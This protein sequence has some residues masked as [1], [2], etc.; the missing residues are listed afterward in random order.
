MNRKLPLTSLFSIKKIKVLLSFGFKGYL[1]DQGWFNAFLSQS[2]VDAENKPIPW[3][4][5]PFIDFIKKRLNK[6][7][8]VFEYGAGN[9]TLFYSN[10]VKEVISVENDK[11]WIEK[12]SKNKPENVNFIYT[13]LFYDGEYSKMPKVLNKEFDIII[14]DGRDRV[15]CCKNSISSLKEGG[16]VILD[17]S[18]REQYSLAF[19]LFKENGFKEISFNG[20]A[21]GL[22][23]TKCTT[24]FYK[25]NN[26]LGI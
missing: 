21:P 19:K 11:A 2:P 1:V 14:V 26:C 18:E 12:L 24:I 16:I 20:I 4:T 9:S 7:L 13:E 17:D 8:T 22:F 3:V 23:H 15:N 6:N 5:Y 25:I 10:L